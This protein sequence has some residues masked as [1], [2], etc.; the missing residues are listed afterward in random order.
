[1]QQKLELKVNAGYKTMK[2]VMKAVCAIK[3]IILTFLA[4]FCLRSLNI[5]SIPKKFLFVFSIHFSV[6]LDEQ[7]LV[8]PVGM[9]RTKS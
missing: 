9:R 6:Y 2:K 5:E 3:G 4:Q 8:R 1:M 7:G